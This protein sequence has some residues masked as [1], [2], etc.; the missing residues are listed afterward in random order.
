MNTFRICLIISVLFSGMGR[1]TAR[2]ADDAAP[3]SRLSGAI[4]INGIVDEAAWSNVHPLPLT[5][6]WPVF[7][8]DITE[9]TE[10]R[11]TYDEEYI[12]VGA[13]CFD[14]DP[15]KIMTP[16][17]QRDK[18]DTNMD[19]VTL[20]LDPYDDNENMLV[21]SVTPSGSR[22]D[23]AIKNDAQGDDIVN[24]S[25]N[26]YWDARCTRN[27]RGWQ[28]EIRI[29]FSS[30]R[31]QESNGTVEMGLT[32]FRYL[33]RKR[34][35][36][37]YP[38]IPPDWGFW[39]FAKASQAQTVS[40]EGV[41]NKRP[42]YI[43]PYALAGLGYHHERNNI[44]EYE[45]NPDRELQAGL[46]VQHAFS[47]N[48]NADF[49]YNTD[50][51]QVE[52]DNQVVNLSRYSLFFPEKRRFFL[53]RASI[54]DF[55]TDLNNNMF[56]SRRIGIKGG[57]MVPLW[58]GA[59]LV[60]RFNTWD[61]GFLS[62]QSKETGDFASENFGVLRLR[63][64]VFNQGSYVGGMMTSRIGMD[65]NKNFV[66]GVDGIINLFKQDYLQVNLAQSWDTGDTTDINIFERSRIYLMWENRIVKGFGY[67][68]SYSSVGEYYKPGLGFEQRY[69]FSQFGDRIFYSWFSPEESSLRQT[70]ITLNGAV[71]LNNTTGDLE[72]SMIGLESRWAWK[73][74]SE[75][76]VNLEHL[77]DDVPGLFKLSDDFIILPA[78]YSNTTMGIRYSTL[79]VGLLRAETSMKAGTFYGGKLVTW[80][81]SPNVSLSKYF[82]MSAFYEH[83]TIVFPDRDKP[84]RS[85]VARLNMVASLNVKVSISGF[86]QFNSLQNISMINF[87]LRYN[88][89]DGNDLY[90]VYNEV[91]NNGQPSDAAELPLSDSRT[92][93]VKYVHTFKP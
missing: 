80:N 20:L 74:G 72:T 10:I 77:E 26:S 21:F 22:I 92:I 28:V 90:L 85:H 88:P 2:P 84:F 4:Q 68:F 66:Y 51:A 8:G 32:V 64:N 30:L 76:A 52:A 41:K 34:E 36:D 14:S 89:A 27:D 46:D 81:I 70:T 40:F 47:D 50:F 73:R 69:N 33:A 78:Q 31:F 25:W 63:K 91:L 54:F 62:M 58:G 12:Y 93:M 86:V 24:L 15:S 18:W 44:G 56:Y 37:M 35:L 38:S 17:F 23:A 39:S 29:P 57:E 7:E 59:R 43:S 67:K 55:K 9:A 16:T 49:T 61:L 6:H 79:P 11:V 42:W 48:L 75:L 82:Q 19:Q 3:I 1:T 71:S 60:G 53:E 45:M 13:V 5:M 87:R 83:N 65:G